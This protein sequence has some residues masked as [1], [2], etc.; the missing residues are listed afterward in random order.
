MEQII[1]HDKQ[2]AGFGEVNFDVTSRLRLTA[3]LRVARTETD[4]DDV[5]NGPLAGGPSTNT[6]KHVETP[7]TPKYVATYRFDSK[8]LVYASVSNGFRIGGVN[9]TI[10]STLC[11]PDLAALGFSTAPQS[12]NSDRVRNYEIGF[13][14]EP[15][16]RFR[17]AASVYYID[18][19]DIIQPVDLVGC[20]ETITTNLG[21]AVSKGADMEF[22]FA[23]VDS[24]L[25]DL[26]VNYNDA[27]FTE[28]IRLPD[29]TSNVVTNGWTL[30]QTPW[31]VVASGQYTFAGPRT[32]TSYLRAD[33]DYR[34]VNNGL[35]AVTDPQSA[36]YDPFLRPNPAT[37]DVRLR[38]GIRVSNWDVSL[39][40]N[41]ATNNHPILNRQDDAVGGAIQYAYFPVRPLTAGLTV[42]AHF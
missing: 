31:T 30:G 23:P 16:E 20:G 12:Y 11:A 5:A 6:G 17:I 37:L 14:S 2:L 19:F 13:K 3:G 9:K 28:T 27:K 22:T 15:T 1:T 24:L 42:E 40:V 18:W 33:V 34:S 32:W 29:A 38:Y 36:T 39:F 25:F 35:T 8:S 41:N 26:M 21:K 7:K 10:S 4:F